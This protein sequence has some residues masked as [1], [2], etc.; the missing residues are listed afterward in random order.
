MALAERSSA[1][2]V[3]VALGLLDAAEEA[4]LQLHDFEALVMYIKAR[5][6]KQSCNL[7]ADFLSVRSWS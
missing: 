2:A 7:R 1:V 6:P 4:L 5:N 3:R